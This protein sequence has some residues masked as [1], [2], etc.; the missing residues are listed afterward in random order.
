[1]TSIFCSLPSTSSCTSRLT[2]R[3]VLAAAS[4]MMMLFV[5]EY[6]VSNPSGETSG[7]RIG[8]RPPA[9]TFVSGTMRVMN[10]S[11]GGGTR[12]PEKVSSVLA[13]ASLEGRILITG[14]L[15]TVVKPFTCS[16]DWNTRYASSTV[17]SDGEMIVTLPFTRSSTMKLLP[18]ISLMNFTR[19]GNSTSWKFIVTRPGFSSSGG[20]GGGGGGACGAGGGASARAA[21]PNGG[22]I[23]FGGSGGFAASAGGATCTG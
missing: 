7:W 12:L 23:T 9:S 17:T 18:V 14:P 2:R 13:L 6:A 11:L 22:G 16:T 21:L 10:S 19:V 5:G 3:S 20:G 4:M 8:N 15:G 1:M